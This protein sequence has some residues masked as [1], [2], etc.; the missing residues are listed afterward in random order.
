MKRA[1]RVHVGVLRARRLTRAWLLALAVA[2]C[3]ADRPKPDLGRTTEAI[4]NGTQSTADQD[5]VVL[6]TLTQPDNT[7][8]PLC[9]GTI[10][11]KNLVLT[12]RHCVG[13]FNEQLQTVTDYGKPSE[14]G[15]YTGVTAEKRVVGQAPNAVAAQIV[16][17]KQSSLVP[18]VGL[19]VLDKPLDAPIASLRLNSG[20]TEGEAIDIVGYGVTEA[21]QYPLER[22]QRTGIPILKNGPA[23]TKFFDVGDG[24]FETGEGECAGDS[25]GPAFSESTGALVGIASRVSNG[26]DR[27]PSQAGA[28]CVGPDTEDVYTTLASAK[29][30]IQ[31]GFDAAGA[32]PVLEEA[33]G[34]A[35]STT[36][37]VSKSGC[38]ASPARPGSLP[39]VALL[40]AA[41]LA[42]RWRRSRRP[43][44]SCRAAP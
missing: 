14:L 18:D 20:V 30:V 21:N 44:R 24:E 3:T 41:V 22:R 32:S 23:T 29:A 12:A 11:A 40:A 17:T 13:E 1:V 15:V 25:G 42:R 37:T 34:G 35:G 16:S 6:I 33:D 27:T 39:S 38:A 2:A 26:K 36:T 10:I 28:F 8:I 43:V 9:T 31:S 19:L 4:V 7:R 5:S